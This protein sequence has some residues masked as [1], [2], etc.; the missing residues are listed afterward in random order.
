MATCLINGNITDPAGT[1]ISSVTI[2]ARINQPVA[3]T[4]SVIVPSEI[5][6]QTDS[7]GNFSLTVQQ[8]LS[9]IFTVQ[10]PPVGTEPQLVYSYTGNIPAATSAQFSSVIVVE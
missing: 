2:S 6:V 4:T 7:S 5:S 9:V 10:Y 8:S 1:A 3:L